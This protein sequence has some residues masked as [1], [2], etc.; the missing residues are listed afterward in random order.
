MAVVELIRPKWVRSL[1][2]MVVSC[3]IVKGAM[4]YWNDGAPRTLPLRYVLWKDGLAFDSCMMN[5]P[6]EELTRKILDDRT[7]DGV[8]S[9]VLSA[10]GSGDIDRTAV[11][12]KEAI[13]RSDEIF[14]EID[15]AP[16]DAISFDQKK[17]PL[18]LDIDRCIDFFDKIAPPVR[19]FLLY[20]VGETLVN[21]GAA[22][23][24]DRWYE[25]VKGSVYLTN[26]IIQEPTL[27]DIQI[28]IPKVLI[29]IIVSYGKWKLQARSEVMTWLL[30]I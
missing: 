28:N 29:E 14:H 18:L 25:I 27:A 9:K 16:L 15:T 22:K 10:C 30:Q 3:D 12:W 8:F 7:T 4:A 20:S 13:R 21:Y 26:M 6:I 23:L 11:A 17:L 1:A 19:G 24:I 5:F 2:T